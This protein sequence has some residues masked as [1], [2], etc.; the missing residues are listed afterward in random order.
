[1][2]IVSVVSAIVNSVLV[3]IIKVF[4]WFTS[5]FLAM[6]SKTHSTYMCTRIKPG[7]QGQAIVVDARY[8]YTEQRPQAGDK[9]YTQQ[10]EVVFFGPPV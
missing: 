8:T 6:H 3:R 4:I 9:K 10:K 2:H 5:F 7:L 1:M